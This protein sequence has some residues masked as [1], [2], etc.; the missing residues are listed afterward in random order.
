[1]ASTN[2]TPNLRLNNWLEN[3]K[4][5]RA[6]FVAD[7]T[8][9][10]SVLGAHINDDDIHL[11]L[12]EKNRVSS[13]YAVSLEYGTGAT[14]LTYNPGFAPSMAIIFKTTTPVVGSRANYPSINFAI[15]TTKGSTGGAALSGSTFTVRQSTT[16]ENGVFYNLNEEDAAYVIIYFK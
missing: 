10:D 3:D 1:M 7:N 2:K 16:T 14:S 15:A 13:P 12:S 8:I 5:K 6:D 11:T 9:I 4:P